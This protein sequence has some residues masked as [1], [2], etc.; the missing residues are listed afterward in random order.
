MGV[1]DQPVQDG[2]GQGRVADLFVPEFQGQLAGH[3][4]GLESMPVFE[5]FQEIMALVPTQ[6][7]K[8]VIIEHQQVCLGHG[9]QQLEVAAVTPG[10]A[11]VLKELGDAQVQRAE[12]LPA[13]L[14]GK[15]AGQVGFAHPGG[16]G[17]DLTGDGTAIHYDEISIFD[18]KPE[19]EMDN[20]SNIIKAFNDQFGN[21]EW[22]D[23][24]KICKVIA[25]EIPAKVAADAA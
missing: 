10:Q 18:R 6:G 3:Q 5:D 21:I 22:K 15:G 12:P 14:V 9:G 8:A 4:G 19:P 7:S 16:T 17:D 20:L 25:E 13:G 1:V 11:H 2:V 24:D 23:G